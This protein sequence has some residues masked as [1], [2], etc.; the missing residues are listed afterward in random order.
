M[1]GDVVATATPQAPIVLTGVGRGPG[2][3][4]DVGHVGRHRVHHGEAVAYEREVDEQP[5]VPP[6]DVGQK[7]AVLIAPV[8][9]ALEAHRRAGRQ[10]VL[11]LVGS[12]P[13]EALHGRPRL[14]RLGGVDTDEADLLVPAR[15]LDGNGV[16]VDYPGHARLAARQRLPVRTGG[17]G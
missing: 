3:L 12:L 8:D 5:I 6:E 11:G 1:Y 10:E 14:H 13:G 17:A 15:H 2:E 7:P 4:L 16:A 9:V